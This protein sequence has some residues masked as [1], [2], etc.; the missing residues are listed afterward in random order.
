MVMREH[1]SAMLYVE[2]AFSGHRQR[3]VTFHALPAGQQVN[4]V[5]RVV[6]AGAGL[7]GPVRAPPRTRLH[8]FHGTLSDTLDP[9][10]NQALLPARPR[11]LEAALGTARAG[12]VGA[13]QGRVGL[14]L[15][16][17]TGCRA[18]CLQDANLTKPVC[19]FTFDF[20]SRSLGQ[21]AIPRVPAAIQC[22]CLGRG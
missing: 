11:L 15:T 10:D 17:R 9:S 2:R 18:R 14:G 22:A 16:L 7:D 20:A 1:C 21:R 5:Q 4:G 8:A 3:A 19:D 13:C 6:G 12:S